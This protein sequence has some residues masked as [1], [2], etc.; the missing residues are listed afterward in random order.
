MLFNWRFWPC[1]SFSCVGACTFLD[2]AFYIC[3]CHRSLST[4]SRPSIYWC[5]WVF[6]TVVHR[7]PPWLQYLSLLLR[8]NNNECIHSCTSFSFWTLEPW[9]CKSPTTCRSR[10]TGSLSHLMVMLTKAFYTSRL[11]QS[12]YTHTTIPQKLNQIFGLY[13]FIYITS[14]YGFLYFISPCRSMYVV[15]L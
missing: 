14:L 4:C 5:L 12:I 15:V 7:F 10:V 11:S 6:V 8:T 9:R 3:I 13:Q 2:L 1:I